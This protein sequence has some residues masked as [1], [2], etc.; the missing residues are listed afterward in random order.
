MFNN[1]PINLLFPTKERPR[2][3]ENSYSYS[4][5]ALKNMRSLLFVILAWVSRLQD[6]VYMFFGGAGLWMCSQ[7]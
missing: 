6:S 1:Y 5:P 3:Q 2:K 7:L 4:R